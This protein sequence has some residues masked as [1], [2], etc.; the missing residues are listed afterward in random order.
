MVGQAKRLLMDYKEKTLTF[1]SGIARTLRVPND[2]ICPSMYTDVCEGTSYPQIYDSAD[3]VKTILDIGAHV[4]T[5]SLYF[6]D[7]YPN[8]EIHA[9]EPC[10]NNFELLQHNT[11]GANI[12][13]HKLGL[14]DADTSMTIYHGEAECMNSC[15]GVEKL[16]GEEECQMADAG[17]ILSQ[18]EKVDICKLDVEGAELRILTTINNQLHRISVLYLEFHR[19]RFRRAIDDLL[20]D[21]FVLAKGRIKAPN[22][23]ELTYV[24]VNEVPEHLWDNPLW[25]G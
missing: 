22:F 14:W 19:M 11:E 4:G 5:A 2:D 24:N 18:F 12:H 13:C 23:G 9:Y 7:C 3:T 25:I 16:K 20:G 6:R 15:L 17:R 10:R 1:A 21:L 8:A